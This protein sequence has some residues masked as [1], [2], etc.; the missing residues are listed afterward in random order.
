MYPALYL[1]LIFKTTWLKCIWISLLWQRWRDFADV[2]EVPNP[3]GARYLG[4]AWPDRVRAAPSWQRHF[5][6]E[7][8]NSPAV[9]GLWRG[10]EQ[11]ASVRQPIQGNGSSRNL[12]ELAGGPW[13]PE[14]NPAG[15]QPW[16][17]LSPQA[18]KQRDDTRMC[19]FN[20]WHLWEWVTTS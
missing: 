10:E 17:S 2:I 20:P 19:C 15:S 1:L 16:E 11:R 12:E 4:W 6:H 8:A 18:W 14:E 13:A 9:N 7:E 3:K 5:G